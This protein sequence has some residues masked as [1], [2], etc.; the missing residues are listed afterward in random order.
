M[1]LQEWI[2]TPVHPVHMRANSAFALGLLGAAASPAVPELQKLLKHDEN[3]LVRSV[4]LE[5]LHRIQPDIAGR[6]YPELFRQTQPEPRI[7]PS[8]ITNSSDP[9]SPKLSL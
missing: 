4:A 1:R 3:G 8:G 7:L 6:F 5:A 2:G 9:F